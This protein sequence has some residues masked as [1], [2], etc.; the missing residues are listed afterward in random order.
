MA[1]VT[2][3]YVD[4]HHVDFEARGRSFTNVRALDADGGPTGFSSVE[5]LLI[6]LGNC[7][8]GSLLNHQL[9]QDAEV[10]RAAATLDARM[11]EFPARV[12]HIDVAITLEVTDEALLG[13][14]PAL[15][16][17]SCACPIC[18]TLDGK[19]TSSLDLRVVAAQH[20]RTASAHRATDAPRSA[21]GRGDS[22]E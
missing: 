3:E 15:E 22:D 8:L 5:L 12:E 9:L 7:T 10:V 1:T 6:A 18:N 14:Y 11:A 21:P 20:E 16:V 17:D 4:R 2:A 13:H 19:V